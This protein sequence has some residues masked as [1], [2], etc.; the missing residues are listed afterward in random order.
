[1]SALRTWADRLIGLSAILASLALAVEVVIILSD[2][3]SRELGDPI[4]G[5]RDIVTMAMVIVVFGGMALCDRRGGHIS[6]DLLERYFP[7]ALNRVLDAFSAALGAVIFVML[8][9]AIYG[10]IA[11]NARFGISSLTNL[12]GLPIDAFRWSF[13]VLSLIAALGMALRAVEIAVSGR[14]VTRTGETSS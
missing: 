8:A 5:S 1:M 14:D 4:Y 9:W 3:I 6:V 7:P 13:I 12:L 11:L 2:V 10:V